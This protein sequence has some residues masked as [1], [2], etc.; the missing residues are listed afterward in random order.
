MPKTTT[1]SLYQ[2]LKDLGVPLDHHESDLYVRDTPAARLVI[3]QFGLKATAF[4]SQIDGQRWL[5]VPFAYEPFWAKKSGRSHAVI[6]APAKS[7]RVPSGQTYTVHGHIWNWRDGS[8]S[9][10]WTRTGLSKSAALKLAAEQRRESGGI[11]TIDP[12]IQTATRPRKTE[13]V[14]TVQGNYGH[15]H[16]WEDLTSEATRAEA[17]Q[18]LKEYRDNEPGVPHRLVKQRVKKS[19]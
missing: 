17:K 2:T 8:K 16:G 1:K 13:D 4:T 5:D 19:A 10:F 3:K 14:W 12:P 11:A 18:R 9:A 15:G 6:A 7:K